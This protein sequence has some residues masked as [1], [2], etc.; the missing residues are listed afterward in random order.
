MKELPLCLQGSYERQQEVLFGQQLAKQ[1][2]R[3][4]HISWNLNKDR[5]RCVADE[6]SGSEEETLSA[7]KVHNCCTATLAHG[8]SAAFKSR[9]CQGGNVTEVTLVETGSTEKWPHF[10]TAAKIISRKE[11]IQSSL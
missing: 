6:T 5:G 10:F 3:L 1:C 8:Q 9:S 11:F 2:Q 4:L 7:S